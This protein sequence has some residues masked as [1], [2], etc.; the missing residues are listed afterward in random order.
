M[1][2]T[3]PPIIMEVEHGPLGDEPVIFQAPILHWTM[4]MGERVIISPDET[5]PTNKL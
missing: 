1:E 4:I 3:L 2:V 5:N